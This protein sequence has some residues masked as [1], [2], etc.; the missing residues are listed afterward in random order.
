MEKNSEN[1]QQTFSS[2]NVLPEIVAALKKS[3]VVNPTPIQEQAIPVVLEGNDLIGI[4][5]TGTGKTVAFAV[6]V[7]QLLNK[8]SGPKDMHTEALIVVPTRE[9]AIQVDSSIQNILRA[10]SPKMSSVVLIG[11]A[12]MYTQTR[13]LRARPRIIVATPGRLQD[14]INQRNYSLKNVQYVVLDEADRMF[15][16]GFAPQ[17]KKFLESAP[18]TKQTLLFSATMP[19]TI[20]SLVKTYLNNPKQIEITPPRTTVKSINQEISYQLTDNKFLTL[21]KILTDTQGKAIVFTKTKHGAANLSEK[22]YKNKISSI[23]IHSNKSLSQRRRA[24]E[25]FKSGDYSVLVATD[26]VARG[27][28]VDNV[29]LVVNFDLPATPDDYIHR[30]GRTGRAGKTGHAI[31]FAIPND[32]RSVREIEKHVSQSL[33]IS[34]YS[35]EEPKKAELSGGGKSQRRGNGRGNRSRT[36]GAVGSASKSRFKSNGRWQSSGAKGSTQDRGESN[37]RSERPQTDFSNARRPRRD[38]SRRQPA[39]SY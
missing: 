5:Q 2:I 23:D 21:K 20:A 14:H 26:V 10:I 24:I 37:S 25:G 22:L 16:M 30:I 17:I 33:I 12:D 1:I 36:S 28:D 11:G 19:P 18:K 8:Q 4:A 34:K 38:Q 35:T 9:L 15:D 29:E 3:G 7:I 13:K 31:S 6:P 27:I 32:V 39:R